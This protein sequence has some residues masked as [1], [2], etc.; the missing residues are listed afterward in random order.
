MANNAYSTV[1][2]CQQ[3]AKEGATIKHQLH[4]TPF[5]KNSLLKFVAVQNLRPVPKTRNGNQYVVISVDRHSNLSRTVVIGRTWPIKLPQKWKTV[6]SVSG[7][8]LR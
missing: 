1:D 8:D 4:L 5:A 3:C 7:K 2:D 6:N